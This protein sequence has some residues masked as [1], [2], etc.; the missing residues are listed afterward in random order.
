M[1]KTIPIFERIPPII[2]PIG[3]T[4]LLIERNQVCISFN[5]GRAIFCRNRWRVR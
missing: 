4:L 5:M 3:K 2:P 1:V